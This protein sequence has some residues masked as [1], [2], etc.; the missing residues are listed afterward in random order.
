MAK[1][2][3]AEMTASARSRGSVSSDDARRV[4]DVMI[5]ARTLEQ[6]IARVYAEG[7]LPGWVHSCEGHEA[8][9][10]AI[11][12]C[13]GADDHLVPHYRSRPEQLGKGMTVREVVAEVF[14]TIHSGSKGRGGETHV[15]S[16][17]SRLYGMTGV[18]GSNI[19]LGAGIA[20]AS[21][22]R[23]LDEV[24]LCS[25]GDGTANRGAFHEGL[26]L[27]AIWDLPVVF[28]CENNVY[29]EMSRTA[30]FVRVANIAD[31]AS[32]YGIPGTA[33]DGHDP[34][35]L[36]EVLTESVALARR[37]QPSLI[38]AKIVRRRGHWE[39]DPQD[40]RS[41][42]ELAVLDEIDPLPRFRQRLMDDY[43]FDEAGMTAIERAARE[44]VQDALEWAQSS[45]LPTASD[46]T[47]GVYAGDTERA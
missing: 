34:E 33:V 3:G 15:S 26:N 21:K 39:G 19:P 38:E 40:Y 23:G 24:T 29:A 22:M 4:Y 2:Y 14:G 31:R 28:V 46:V 17:S 44:T 9:G 18:L 30:D 6:E 36:I 27:A 1:R 16:R 20:Y 43:G 11:A 13:L 45:P 25:F 47:T 41:R 37:G 42:E 32:A 8:L 7:K 12:I 5:T 35:A 10:G